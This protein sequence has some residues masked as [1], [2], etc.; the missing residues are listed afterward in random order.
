MNILD[1]DESS[2]NQD[3]RASR[4]K[5]IKRMKT[6]IIVIVLVLL[7][8]PTLIS[9]IMM[10]KVISLQKQIDILMIDRYGVTYHNLNDEHTESVAHAATTDDS[11][12]EANTEQNDEELENLDQS[13]EAKV[14]ADNQM[15]TAE[16]V[17]DDIEKKEE[18]LQEDTNTDQKFK[19]KKVYLTFDD[20]PSKYTSD[21]LDILAD[22]NAKATFFVI[23]KTDKYSKKMYQ[24][25]VEEGHTLGMH[26]YSHSYSSIYKSVE[27]FDKDFTKLSDLLYDITGYLPSIYRF[28]GGSSNKVSN[29]DISVFIKYLN[30]KS[31][32]YYDWNVVN[33]DAT[34]D[35]L[36]SKELYENVITGV[37]L[38]NTSIVLM[39][40]TDAKEKTVNSLV[41]I[42]QTLIE[43]GAAILPL[44]ES[45]SPIQQVKT[46]S[47]EQ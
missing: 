47:F 20:G 13:E 44:D 28:P 34:G 22:Y 33:G 25:I 10:S 11:I 30:D 36:T 4:Q 7:I 41:E 12:R 14:N 43:E 16:V 27:D 35:S 31:V 45:V 17:T 29:E 19:S 8:L 6:W 32:V 9:F 37:N 39:H 38:H 1:I 42:L 46:S 24:R 3:A 5:R 26:S 18:Q 15:K 40:D 23:G 21:I 2:S